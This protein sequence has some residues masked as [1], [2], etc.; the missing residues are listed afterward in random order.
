MG[1]HFIRRGWGEGILNKNKYLNILQQ[2]LK[3]SATT[4][5]VERTFKYYQN[6]DPKHKA[7]I[8]QEYL[9]YN[10]TQI[11]HPPQQSPNLNPIEN[12]WDFLDR[13]IQTTPIKSKEELK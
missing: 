13:K 11:L 10:C 9:L 5:D 12:V 3:K 8:V 7:R 6:N 4:I 2:N 1:M